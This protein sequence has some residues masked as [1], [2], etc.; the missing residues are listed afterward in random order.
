LNVS[1]K[2]REVIGKWRRSVREPVVPKES[3]KLRSHSLLFQYSVVVANLS[4][5][6]SSLDSAV[7]IAFPAITAAFSL[8]VASIQWVVVGYVLT[9]ASLL[10]GCGRLADLWGHGRLLTWGLLASAVAFVGCGLAPTFAWLVVARVGQG[11]AAALV[12]ASAPA[13][14]TLAVPGELRGRALGIFQ[15]S[16]AAGYALGPLIGG[17]LVDGFG[18]RAVYLFRLLPALFLAWLAA[19]KLP[20]FRERREAQCFDLLGAL[21]LAGSIGGF[22]LGISRGRSL[23]WTSPH[24]VILL[25]VSAICFGGFLVTETRARAPVV[26]LSL[27]RRPSFIIANLLT[28]LANCARFA[29]GLLMPYYVIDVLRYPATTGGSL[30][31]AVAMMTTIAAPVTGRLSDRFGTARLS[32]LGLALEGLGL[33]MISRLDARADYLSLAVA[34]GVVGLGLGVFEAPNMS[35]VM[36]AIPRTQQGVAGSIN[37]MARTLGIVFG[38]TGASL[39]FDERRRFYSEQRSPE[40]PA[41]FQGFVPA[42][43]EVFL[44]AAGLCVLAFGLSLLR[45]REGAESNAAAKEN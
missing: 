14:V 25:L 21:T 17:L 15:M 1:D 43:Q 42:F 39:I 37:N 22:L 38:A 6:L 32:S 3:T 11:V 27:F 4:T 7:N 44:F 13:L 33:W 9:H 23:G 20:P 2:G 40:V 10:L 28:V 29:I 18:W 12:S 45:R 41:D 36:G 8:E 35:F 26:N 5:L 30:M 31:L 34:L 24:V 19:V 16:A